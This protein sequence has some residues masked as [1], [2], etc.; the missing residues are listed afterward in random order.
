MISSSVLDLKVRLRFILV[1]ACNFQC[2]KD[3]NDLQKGWLSLLL[4][5]SPNKD[6]HS[7]S[8]NKRSYLFLF[9]L[10]STFETVSAQNRLPVY[11]PTRS[12]A[13]IYRLTV[14]SLEPGPGG[15]ANNSRESVQ[16]DLEQSD[17]SQSQGTYK[18]RN[19]DN[20]HLSM[21][22]AVYNTQNST[23]V[24]ETIAFDNG[25]DNYFS[26]VF[27]D[28]NAKV[29][30]S[31]RVDRE[32]R[33]RAIR[34]RLRN[35]VA[36]SPAVIYFYVMPTEKERVA[37]SVTADTRTAVNTIEALGEA[38]DNNQCYIKQRAEAFA[39]SGQPPE[40]LPAWPLRGGSCDPIWST[41]SYPAQAK[42]HRLGVAINEGC[43][44][45]SYSNDFIFNG[46]QLLESTPQI[47]VPYY[48]ENGQVARRVDNPLGCWLLPD[49]VSKLPTNLS[50]A[51]Q[52]NTASVRRARI[53]IERVDQFIQ[54]VSGPVITPNACK[55]LPLVNFGFAQNGLGWGQYWSDDRQYS[56]NRAQVF[57]SPSPASPLT[58]ELITR[59]DSDNSSIYQPVVPKA[60]PKL[61][62]EIG[63]YES[64]RLSAITPDSPQCSHFV[65]MPAPVQ[66]D[67]KKP[68]GEDEP[69]LELVDTVT[70]PNNIRASLYGEFDM[71]GKLLTTRL[72][73]TANR[74]AAGSL[75][76]RFAD[77][78][79][80]RAS[81]PL[82]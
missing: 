72:R 77:T 3:S 46:K 22:A 49:N 42:F 33:G 57:V 8:L 69:E 13:W 53:K 7:M 50:A 75:T 44:G 29:F 64:P 71:N 60:I 6:G 11:K 47:N 36:P 16:K 34:P 62:F 63:T 52:Q 12:G 55:L 9:G 25:S 58:L 73:F 5:T 68:W 37:I 14:E 74:P 56:G 70:G 21:S 31:R 4:A 23:H 40:K 76:R 1:P 45:Y 41:F 30:L 19:W 18:I 17:Q 65:N 79:L 38:K 20:D 24:E 51:G 10:A 66:Q 61:K 2:E 39:R 26:T 35:P 82:F 59:Y 78:L 48:I 28:E 32:V 80:H 81:A 15:G 54:F 43:D 27:W 67:Y